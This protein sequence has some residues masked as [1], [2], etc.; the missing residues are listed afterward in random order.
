MRAP[1]R[2]LKR[3]SS[4][5]GSG[6]VAVD[7]TGSLIQPLRVPL[8]YT[9]TNKKT[10]KGKNTHKIRPSTKTYNNNNTNNYET[11]IHYQHTN[12]SLQNNTPHPKYTT[13]IQIH[14][15]PNNIHVSK[16]HCGSAFELDNSGLPYYCTPPVCFPDV[17]GALTVWRRN[18][19]TKKRVQ[20]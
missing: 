19:K 9:W 13:N 20:Y 7:E 5:S 8:E 6:T 14:P 17:I 12:T 2:H 15:L 11:Y 18:N 3:P 4:P 1:S 16:V 10:Q